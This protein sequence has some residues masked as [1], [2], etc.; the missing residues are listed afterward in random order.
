MKLKNTRL[1]VVYCEICS[2]HSAVDSYIS[3]AYSETLDRELTDDE[4]DEFTNEYA[5]EVQYYSYS[6]GGSC[7]HN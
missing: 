5:G 2:E 1:G 6:E 7:N 4:L 3:S